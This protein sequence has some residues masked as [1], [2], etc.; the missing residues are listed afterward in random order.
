MV[1]RKI[2]PDRHRG[3]SWRSML[4]KAD[5]WE[6]IKDTVIANRPKT[7][8]QRL[9]HRRLTLWAHRGCRAASIPSRSRLSKNALGSAQLSLAASQ[10]SDKLPLLLRIN[11]YRLPAKGTMENRIPGTPATP[12]LCVSGAPRSVEAELPSLLS[13]PWRRRDGLRSLNHVAEFVHGR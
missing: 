5:G 4:L 1:E 10:T 3:Q 6:R 7:G 13:V 12:A 2:L 9:C 8:A 11:A